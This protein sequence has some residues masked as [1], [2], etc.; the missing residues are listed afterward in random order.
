[1]HRMKPHALKDIP[2]EAIA[3]SR[4]RQGVRHFRERVILLKRGAKKGTPTQQACEYIN[5]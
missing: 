3:S 1:M 2:K 5:G 4:E